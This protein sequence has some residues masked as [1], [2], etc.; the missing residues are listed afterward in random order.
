MSN[1]TGINC[2]KSIDT[3]DDRREILY[4]LLLLTSEERVKFICHTINEI[5]KAVKLTHSPPW[6]LLEVTNASGEANETYVD[7]MYAISQYKI[8]PQVVLRA[9]E[10]LVSTKTKH[11][12]DSHI[13]NTH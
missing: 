5:N 9:L 10:N 7:L 8:D 3:K 12:I 1:H 2:L 6:V 13:R 4:L 11:S